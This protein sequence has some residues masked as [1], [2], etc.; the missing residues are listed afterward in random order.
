MTTITDKTV[1]EDRPRTIREITSGPAG[2]TDD[3]S[4]T[5]LPTYFAHVFAVVQF[6][7][8]LGE[9]VVPTAGT[10]TFSIQTDEGSPSYEPPEEP[11]IDATA[12]TMISWAGN[13]PGVKAVPAGLV[14][15]VTWRIK[16]LFNQT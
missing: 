6:F 8:G 4:L 2:P 7:D 10:V 9:R 16:L 3:F 12:P 5:G 15:V 11:V 14:G 1:T 13:T